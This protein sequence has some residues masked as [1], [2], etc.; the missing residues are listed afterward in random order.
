MPSPFVPG[1]LYTTDPEYFLLVYPTQEKA[2]A[3]EPAGG[4]AA[5]ADL[6]A[7]AEQAAW[8]SKRLGC[9]IRYVVP[10]S[11]F[12]VVDNKLSGNCLHVLFG[13]FDGWIILANWLEFEPV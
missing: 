9:Q 11:S 12:M 8:W 7:A 2:A 6:A 10:K 4:A 13:D 3:A 1:K 5:A